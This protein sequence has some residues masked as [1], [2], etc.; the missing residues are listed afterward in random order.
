MIRSLAHGRLELHRDFPKVSK[1]VGGYFV[2]YMMYTNVM[3]L[4]VFIYCN[5]MYGTSSIHYIYIN[6]YT[7]TCINIYPT[8][9]QPTPALLYPLLIASPLFILP[10]HQ[11][12]YLSPHPLLIPTRPLP[13]Q[14][15]SLKNC[16]ERAIPYF[17]N[18]IVPNSIEMNKSVLVASSENAIRGLLVWVIL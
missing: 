13:S 14:A 8:S 6:S 18:V 15:E 1:S 9:P 11:P 3:R 5:H 17:T 7:L 12:T 16:M 10:P 2:T 4:Y